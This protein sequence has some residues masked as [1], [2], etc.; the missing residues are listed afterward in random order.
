M[1]EGYLKVDAKER[2]LRTYSLV[3]LLGAIDIPT[4]RA[5]VGY[6]RPGWTPREAIKNGYMVIV[7]GARLINQESAQ[8]YLFTQV[9][10]LIM[11]EINKRI[12]ADPKDQPVSLVLDEVYSLLSIPGMAQEIGRISP[13]YRSRKLELYIVLQAL[14]QLSKELREQV[15]S[16]G[17]IMS[18]AVSNFEEAYE[19]A[20]QIF[21]YNPEIVKLDFISNTQQPVL[22]QDRGQYLLIANDIQRMK[23]RECIIRR[24][25]SEKQ[26]DKYIRWVPITANVSVAPIH[27]DDIKETLLQKCGVRVRDAL[28]KIDQ[29]DIPVETKTITPPKIK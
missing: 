2:D 15:W 23:H 19:L 22:E 20:Q 9:Y 24:Y 16:I 13:Q 6:Y 21:K 26:L 11:E 1:D 28:E 4:A 10:S 3:S 8:Y 17:N 5:R 18:F 12:P 7:N 14:S 27:L 25:L 29:R